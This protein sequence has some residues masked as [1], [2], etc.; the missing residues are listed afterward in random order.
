MYAPGMNGIDDRGTLNVGAPADVAIM[1][2]R[3]GTFDFLDNYKGVRTGKQ[4]L[5]PAGTVLA[6][7]SVVRARGT[8]GRASREPTEQVAEWIPGSR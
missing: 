5:F 8:F 2:L 1:E 3:D 7:K 6:G 4:R